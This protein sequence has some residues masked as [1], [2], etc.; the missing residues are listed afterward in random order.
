MAL[1]KA[2]SIF[3]RTREL[4]GEIDEFMDNLAQSALAFKRAVSI[5][6]ADGRSPEFDEKL[7]QVND[8]E[9]RSDDLRRAVERK[10]YAQTLIPESRGDVL[11]L[12][13][14]L[15]SVLN[16]FEGAL[17]GFS[18]ENPDIPAQY[19]EDYRSLA[20]QVTAAVEALVLASRAFFRNVEMVG[21]HMHKVI[22]F[23]KEADKVSTKLKR[24]IFESDLELARKLH[25]R[26]FVE[27]IDNIAD[28]AEDVADRLAIYAIKRRF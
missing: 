8:L 20:E 10:L 25:L 22:F 18:I 15:D 24:Q 4:E 14:N 2:I 9:S 5:F 13:E 28:R 11:G 26:H 27:L 23:E 17:W 19:H 1:P 6:L 3:R 12:L 21:D 16:N 7:A